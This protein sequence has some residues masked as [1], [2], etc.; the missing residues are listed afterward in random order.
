MFTIQGNI[1]A[2]QVLKKFKLIFEKNSK[3]TKTH[4]KITK[5][6]TKIQKQTI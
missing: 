5:S 1:F 3:M 6:M 4:H 2:L